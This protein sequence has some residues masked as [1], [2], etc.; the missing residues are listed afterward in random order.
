MELFLIA[1]TQDNYNLLPV[2]IPDIAVAS[3]NVK[4]PSPPGSLEYLQLA[5]FLLIEHALGSAG[6][7]IRGA[8]T[9]LDWIIYFGPSV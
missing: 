7:A 4:E 2:N 1:G 5:E 8:S 6:G 9:L 3:D